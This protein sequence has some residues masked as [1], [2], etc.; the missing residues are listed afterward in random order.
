MPRLGRIPIVLILFNCADCL[1][2]SGTRSSH[3]GVVLVR[4]ESAARADRGAGS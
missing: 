4:R 1:A 3:S 2:A